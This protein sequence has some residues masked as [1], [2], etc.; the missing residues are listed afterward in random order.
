[1]SHDTLMTETTDDLLEQVAAVVDFLQQNINQV[2]SPRDLVSLLLGGDITLPRINKE[3]L[4]IIYRSFGSG[5]Y[6]FLAYKGVV[7]TSGNKSTFTFSADNPA[8]KNVVEKPNITQEQYPYFSTA[9]ACHGGGFV[10]F[11]S[12]AI[13]PMRIDQKRCQGAFILHH[14]NKCDAYLPST[15]RALDIVGDRLAYLIQDLHRGRRERIAS[16]LRNELLQ[17]QTS[18]DSKKAF[19]HE[20]DILQAVAQG[21]AKWYRHDKF[22]ILIKNPL[23]VESYF[24]ANDPNKS[25]EDP[26]F[27]IRDFRLKKSLNKNSPELLEVVG[28]AANLAKMSCADTHYQGDSKTANELLDLVPVCQAW[29]GATLYHPDGYVSGHIILHNEKVANA[30]N[31]S[32]VRFLDSIADFAGLL[33]AKFRT[34]KKERFI[35]SMDDSHETDKEKLY[36]QLADYLQTLY[37]VVNF[38]IY[39]INQTNLRW[40]PAWLAGGSNFTQAETLDV[41]WQNQIQN[42][43][44]GYGVQ[45]YQSPKLFQKELSD[46]QFLFVPMRAGRGDANR[47]VI[48]CLALPTGNVYPLSISIL[49]E[50]TDAL[51]RRLYSLENSARYDALSAFG[52]ALS[53]LVVDNSITREK[54]L[55]VA[56]DHVGQVM[57]SENLYIALYDHATNSIHFPWI[58]K[59]GQPWEAMWDKT[60]PVDKAKRGRTEEIILS[61]EPILISTLAESKAWYAEPNRQEFAGNPLA[62]WLGVPIFRAK[63]ANAPDEAGVLGVIAV[64]HPDLEH[65]YSQRDAF[66]LKE[67]AT[68]ISGLF[69]VLDLKE[70]NRRLAQSNMLIKKQEELV[71]RYL[72]RNL[73]SRIGKSVVDVK[74]SFNVIIEELE[75]IHNTGDTSPLQDILKIQQ[76]TQEKFSDIIEGIESIKKATTDV[77]EKFFIPSV[78]KV[79]K[80]DYYAKANENLYNGNTSDLHIKNKETYF[81]VCFSLIFDA[82]ADLNNDSIKVSYKIQVEGEI[83]IKIFILPANMLDEIIK[84]EKINLAKI[85]LSSQFNGELQ[86]EENSI[87]VSITSDRKKDIKVGVIA[88]N[89]TLKTRI[90]QILREYGEDYSFA[91]S[92]LLDILED[93]S[94]EFDIVFTNS[95]YYKKNNS[96]KIFSCKK[97]LIILDDD[98]DHISDNNLMTIKSGDLQEREKYLSVFDKLI[99]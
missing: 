16:D 68:H 60:R 49:D 81:Y 76:D 61:G 8:I 5:E 86:I 99:H 96:N 32:D 31:E 17:R 95:N 33:L 56:Y 72:A 35:R 80:N 45:D 91:F 25:P 1:M 24:L 12:V 11:S 3:E 87:V 51:A 65:V 38:A 69:R 66:F 21:L 36:K 18:N 4:S 82:I 34:R 57:Y 29:L 41:A 90:K 89:T 63:D 42:F 50:V 10:G 93:L 27:I 78:L 53:Q 75:Y 97:V 9:E 20:A 71:K 55:K 14:P 40:Q 52:K 46:K 13:V 26:D 67:V 19:Q 7:I 54:V 6:E 15:R 28:S 62:S 30:Y 39:T 84:N 44:S 64:Y 83:K 74:I 43:P 92:D 37:G 59:E 94:E 85:L 2:Q 98:N 47:R 77:N 79:A 88:L 73:D 70:A 22:Y 58:Y 23:D 48:G